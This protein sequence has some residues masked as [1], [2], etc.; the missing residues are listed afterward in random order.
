MLVYTKQNTLLISVTDSKTKKSKNI[1]V[2]V[3]DK[4]DKSVQALKDEVLQITKP[5]V[6]NTESKVALLFRYDSSK[7]AGAISINTT[8]SYLEVYEYI[9]SKSMPF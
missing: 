2:M 5:L 9:I 7:R 1:T 6:S 3:R 8:K 4:S